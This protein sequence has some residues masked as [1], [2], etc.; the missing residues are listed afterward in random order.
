[1]S[2]SNR[3]GCS[4]SAS[5][6][7]PVLRL[8]RSPVFLSSCRCHRSSLDWRSSNSASHSCLQSERYLRGTKRLIH[9]IN[10]RWGLRCCF[11][12]SS[13]LARQFGFGSRQQALYEPVPFKGFG[14]CVGAGRGDFV[15][16]P[17]RAALVLGES[18]SFP[19]GIDESG[20]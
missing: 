12:R 20:L 1:M 8:K 2:S 7:A 10:H 14:E 4:Q 5:H 3:R 17:G 9:A 13:S 16:P 11:T 18:L 6:N 15:I 19:F